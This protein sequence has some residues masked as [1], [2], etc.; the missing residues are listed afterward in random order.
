MSV[1]F[2]RRWWVLSVA[3]VAMLAVKVAFSAEFVLLVDFAT[4]ICCCITGI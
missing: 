4:H 3:I 2:S 1:D